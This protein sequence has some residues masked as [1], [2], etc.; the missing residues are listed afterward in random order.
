LIDRLGDEAGDH[1]GGAEAEGDEDGANDQFE[2]DGIG[3][4]GWRGEG[5]EEQRA[6]G[7]D[8][9]GD[10]PHKAASAQGER[11]DIGE[12]VGAH[13]VEVDAEERPLARQFNQEE[14]LRDGDEGRDGEGDGQMPED[15]GAEA[16]PDAGERDEEDGDAKQPCDACDN[17]ADLRQ[18]NEAAARAVE[19]D[20]GDGGAGDEAAAGVAERPDDGEPRGD[21]ERKDDDVVNDDGAD[22]AVLQLVCG[23][24]RSDDGL[25]V[26]DVEP[27]ADD[28]REERGQRDDQHGAAAREAGGLLAQ[29]PWAEVV[30]E[31]EKAKAGRRG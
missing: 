18:V 15:L 7:A 13:I 3:V 16:V 11:V 21:A 28:L 22:E 29:I 23:E 5:H 10:S 24:E 26:P 19:V 31:D 2:P 9:S 17:G 30:E 8:A 12:A 1:G 4:G 6:D 20:V 25:I 14:T 27:T